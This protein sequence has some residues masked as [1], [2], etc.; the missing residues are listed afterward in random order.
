MQALE[1]MRDGWNQRAIARAL[2]VTEA[3]VSQWM[4]AAGQG[5]Q[6]AL[7]AHPAPGPI[8]KLDVGKDSG[9]KHTQG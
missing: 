7:R 5:G 1:L 6:E 8:P 9:K 2:G 4:A 3:A